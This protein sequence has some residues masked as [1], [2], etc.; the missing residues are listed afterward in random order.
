M[1]LYSF[2]SVPAATLSLSLLHAGLSSGRA[3]GAGVSSFLLY[4]RVI[5]D[6]DLEG[7]AIFTLPAS[8]DGAPALLSYWLHYFLKQNSREETY[9]ARMTITSVDLTNATAIWPFSRR[10]SRTASAVM[11]DVRCW[12][13][14]ERVT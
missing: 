8:K 14:M 6:P 2:P 7:Q 1:I 9:S 4:H 11:M 3:S 5:H 12:P 10:I 13:A